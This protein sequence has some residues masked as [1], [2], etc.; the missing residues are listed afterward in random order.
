MHWHSFQ[1]AR[2]AV[3]SP[4]QQL[5]TQGWAIIFDGGA[6]GA[7]SKI[8]VSGPRPLFSTAGAWEGGSYTPCV[9]S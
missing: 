1:P 9:D 7:H 2:T 5:L 4:Q 6:N 8:S 3:S